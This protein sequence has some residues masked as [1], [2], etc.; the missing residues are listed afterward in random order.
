MPS[1]T[2]TSTESADRTTWWFVPQ[3]R[4][5]ETRRAVAERVVQKRG[6]TVSPPLEVQSGDPF[7][8]IRYRRTVGPADELVILPIDAVVVDGRR[9]ARVLHADG[10][11]AG[12]GDAERLQPARILRV[13]E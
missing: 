11:A 3:L 2:T 5:G 4:A 9:Q 13:V 7:G 10:D 12:R 6:R 1:P 8:L